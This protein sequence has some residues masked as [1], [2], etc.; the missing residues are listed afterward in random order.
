LQLQHSRAGHR[1]GAAHP[2][3]WHVF[4]TA[5]QNDAIAAVELALAEA[6]R[7]GVVTQHVVDSPSRR[8]GLNERGPP[9]EVGVSDAPTRTREALHGAP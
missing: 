3:G 2:L 7:L 9:G 4:P 6:E 8:G 1:V 5:I